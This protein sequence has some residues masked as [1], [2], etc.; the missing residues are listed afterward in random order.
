MIAWLTHF[1]TDIIDIINSI[2]NL[3]KIQI[4]FRTEKIVRLIIRIK[5][6]I[7]FNEVFSKNNTGEK[8][9]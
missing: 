3:S 9:Q 5:I 1:L 8:S 2:G 6:T 7:I 4:Q